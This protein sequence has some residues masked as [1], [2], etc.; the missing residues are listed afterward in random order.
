MENKEKKQIEEAGELDLFSARVCFPKISFSAEKDSLSLARIA[1][2]GVNT[3]KEMSFQIA[4]NWQLVGIRK[5]NKG[6]IISCGFTMIGD[7]VKIE[8]IVQVKMEFKKPLSEQQIFN[9]MSCQVLA[10]KM[11]FPYLVEL[12]AANTSKL[13]LGTSPLILDNGLLNTILDNTVK[14]GVFQ[15]KTENKVNPKRNK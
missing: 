11:F 9:S 7:P 4:V 8:L 15:K 13:E 12:V 5:D 1:A 10:A 3:I 14:Q 2:D 6:I